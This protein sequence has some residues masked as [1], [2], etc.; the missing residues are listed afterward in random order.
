M[1]AVTITFE[2]NIGDLVK[3]TKD[4]CCDTYGTYCGKVIELLVEPDGRRKF[5]CEYKADG[6]LC[7]PDFYADELEPWT[8]NADGETPDARDLEPG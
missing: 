6:R 2:H 3:I 1:P 8:E 5:C 4:K 7:A